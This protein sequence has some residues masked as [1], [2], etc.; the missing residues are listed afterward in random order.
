MLCA[1]ACTPP[2]HQDNSLTSLL[3]QQWQALLVAIHL[4]PG[5]DAAERWSDFVKRCVVLLGA[6]THPGGGK[7]VAAHL[8]PR[9][10]A[11]LRLARML[12]HFLE[13]TTQVQPSITNTCTKSIIDWVPNHSRFRM[14][15]VHATID[16]ITLVPRR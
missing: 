8:H 3:R 16:V 7:A 9:G 6:Q 12:Q 2:R 11:A 10:D 1:H 14:F 13:E 5:T 4:H 15:A